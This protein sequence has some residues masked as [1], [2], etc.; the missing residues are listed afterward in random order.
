MRRARRLPDIVALIVDH[1]PSMDIRG[2]RAEADDTA[3]AIKSDAR[4]ATRA[5]KSAKPMSRRRGPARTP[6]RNCSRPCLP[7]WPMCRPIA[8]R[9]PSPSP[10][11][12]CTTRLTSNKPPLKAPFHALIVDQP[13]ERDRKLTV[14]SAAR[15]AIVGQNADIAHPRRRF[16]LAVRRLCRCGC[17]AST[18]SISASASCPSGRM[19]PSQVN[20]GACRRK[21]HRA[22]SAARDRRELTL[23]NNRAVVVVNGVRDRL[24]RAADLGRAQC[25]RARV[26]QS[27]EGRSVGRSRAFHNSA[28]AR[29]AGRG[30]HAHRRV[31]ADRHFR[32]RELFVEKLDQFDLVIFDRY[33]RTGHPAARLFRKHRALC[34]RTAARCWCRPDRNSPSRR[35]SIRTP[36][37]AVL[38]A[39]PT[40]EIVTQGFKP[41]VTPQGLAH[42]VTR[43]LPGANDRTAQRPAG[44]AGSG[45]SAPRKCRARRVMSGPGDK[46]LLVLD[47]VGKGRVAE[48]LSDQAWLWARGFE[49]GGPARR[50]AA[51]A[52][53]LADERA[54]AG[55]RAS[56]R[57]DRKRTDLRR[58][59]DHGRDNRRP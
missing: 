26:A 30:S 18:A 2:R 57:I 33:Q 58:A 15:Y 49:G 34:R 37:A 47:N 28:P 32:R 54:G 45:S 23:E 51:P 13:N 20:I 46:P 41:M 38:P 19:R 52:R 48:L 27:A 16:R 22:G 50:I 9:A 1:S 53:T 14:V 42:P 29:E 39:Q 17:A 31:V 7:H 4:V 10:T 6:A 56:L 24:A 8:W 55:R 21:R 36:L 12:K 59:P 25:G 11:A 5:S 3:A 35:A 43:D 44:A 40:G